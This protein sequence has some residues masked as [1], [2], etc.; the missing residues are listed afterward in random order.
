MFTFAAAAYNLIRRR[1]LMEAPAA[2]TAG[3][4]FFQSK[5]PPSEAFFNGLPDTSDSTEYVHVSKSTMSAA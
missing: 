5:I 4:R 2:Q 3:P 1:N